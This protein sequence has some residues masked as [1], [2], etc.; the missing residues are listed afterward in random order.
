MTSF[1]LR[2]PDG[3]TLETVKRLLAKDITCDRTKLTVDV[4]TEL[5]ELCANS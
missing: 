2:V 5:Q 3:T 1:L 4:I